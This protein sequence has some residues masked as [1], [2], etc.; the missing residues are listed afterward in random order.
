ME[1]RT[2]MT[3]QQTMPLAIAL[4]RTLGIPVASEDAVELE[5]RLTAM[6]QNAFAKGAEIEREACAKVCEAGINKATDWDSSAWDQ[7]CENRALAI[8]ARGQA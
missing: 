8:R 3:E 7:A 6:I 1:G 4:S 5:D 2:K